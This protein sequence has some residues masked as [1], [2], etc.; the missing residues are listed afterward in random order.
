MCSHGDADH[1]GAITICKED[2]GVVTVCGRKNF[3]A[4]MNK[5]TSQAGK[6][7]RTKTTKA[8][9]KQ[10]LAILCQKQWAEYICATADKPLDAQRHERWEDLS[11]KRTPASSTERDV[12]MLPIKKVNEEADGVNESQKK[13]TAHQVP[14]RDGRERDAS[15]RQGTTTIR[16]HFGSSSLHSE[17]ESNGTIRGFC[18][19]PRQLPS[20]HGQLLVACVLSQPSAPWLPLPALPGRGESGVVGGAGQ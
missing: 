1:G 4:D 13:G 17:L 8:I 19:R 16:R 20:W 3:C 14:T 5:H 6:M 11:L 12:L 18:S 10:S 15:A 9:G 7:S 2:W